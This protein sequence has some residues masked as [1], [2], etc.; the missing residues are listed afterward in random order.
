M[1]GAFT[2][3]RGVIMIKPFTFTP[4][5]QFEWFRKDLNKLIGIYYPGMT[6]NCTL[7]A[8]HDLLRAKCDEWEAEGIIQII[9]LKPNQ[10]FITLEINDGDST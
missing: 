8:R 10:R 6:Y 2:S 3:Q 1:V 4:L 9:A 7:D 5:I